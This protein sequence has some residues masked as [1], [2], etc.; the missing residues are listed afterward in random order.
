MPRYSSGYDEDYGYKD[1]NNTSG[2]T[3]EE[4]VEIW[5]NSFDKLYNLVRDIEE[6]MHRRERIEREYQK[7]LDSI[8]TTAGELYEIT[9]K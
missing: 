4:E 6:E 5:E 7:T 8:G 3:E 2:T 9:R 1:K